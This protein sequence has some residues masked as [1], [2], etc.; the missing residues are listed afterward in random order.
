MNDR[1]IKQDGPAHLPAVD[2][3]GMMGYEIRGGRGGSVAGFEVEGFVLRSTYYN[4][5]RLAQPGRRL[6]QGIQHALQVERRA[7]DHLEHVRGSGLLLQ[8]LAQLVEQ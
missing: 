2:S 8:R 6:D 7:A 3:A 1:A 4:R 5:V